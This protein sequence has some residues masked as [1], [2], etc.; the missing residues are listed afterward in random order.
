ML[1]VSMQGAK[2]DLQYQTIILTPAEREHYYVGTVFPA[3]S[4][5]FQIVSNLI[6]FFLSSLLNIDQHVCEFSLLISILII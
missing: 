1:N 2:I 6:A 5:T 4:I 3:V